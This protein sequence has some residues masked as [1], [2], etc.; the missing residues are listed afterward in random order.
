MVNLCFNMGWATLSTFR[1]FLAAMQAGHWEAAAAELDWLVKLISNVRAVRA[2]MNVP[3][4]AK[5]P[6][7]IRG[8]SDVTTQRLTTHAAIIQTLA[9]AESVK[10]IDASIAVKGAVQVVVD[11]A[12]VLLP[13]ADVIDVAQEKARLSKE[14]AKLTGEVDKIDKKLGNVAFVA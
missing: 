10:T 1:N 2:E 3:P 5:V 6:L 13:L 11:E 7:L 14:I 9:R 8:A 12:T 4:S